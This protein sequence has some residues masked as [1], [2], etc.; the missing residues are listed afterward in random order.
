MEK[1]REEIED[2]KSLQKVLG[3]SLR[4]TELNERKTFQLQHSKQC[5]LAYGSVARAAWP[6]FGRSWI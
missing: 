6:A 3:V 2:A 4:D 5:C 1:E